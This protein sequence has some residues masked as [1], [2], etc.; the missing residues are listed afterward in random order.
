MLLIDLFN[1]MY[2][3]IMIMLVLFFRFLFLLIRMDILYCDLLVNI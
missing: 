2:M 3:S 1:L